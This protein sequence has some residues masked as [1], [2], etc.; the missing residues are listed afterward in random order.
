MTVRNKIFAINHAIRSFSASVF[1][2][3]KRN[4]RQNRQQRCKTWKRMRKYR[5]YTSIAQY[6]DFMTF[7]SDSIFYLLVAR[8]VHLACNTG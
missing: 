7:P 1:Q 5:I 2:E 6:N 4:D 8:T 3:R